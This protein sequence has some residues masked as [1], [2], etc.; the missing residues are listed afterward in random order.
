MEDKLVS[1]IVPVYNVEKYLDQCVKS[2]VDQTYRYLEIILVDDGSPDNCPQICDKWAEEDP[3]I[4]VIH[5]SNGGLSDARNAGMNVAAGEY[6]AFVDSDDFIDERMYATMVTAMQDTGADVASCG[7]VIFD[8]ITSKKDHVLDCARVYSAKDGLSELLSGG[9][10]EEAVWDKVYKKSL[11]DGVSF[12]VGEI[13]EDLVIT[14][15]ILLK[16]H[17]IVHVGEAYYFYRV[18]PNSISKVN[19]NENK[20][21]VIKHICDFEN[22]VSK[23]YPELRRELGLF[24]ARYSFPMLACMSMDS[25]AI[26]IYADDYRFYHRVMKRHLREY[27]L[28]K[29]VITKNKVEAILLC[30]GLY[31]VVLKIKDFASNAGKIVNKSK[32]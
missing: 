20:R 21:I 11:F 15:K 14:P 26:K 22:M 16:S 17:S 5:K 23:K 13:N 2:I 30:F 8:G 6:I 24:L 9:S 18:N 32:W 31:R 7:R 28:A 12:P 4:K 27:I 25:D 19:Y 29:S 10:I 1:I 3:R